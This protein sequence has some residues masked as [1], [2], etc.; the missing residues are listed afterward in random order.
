MCIECG[1]YKKNPMNR[2]YAALEKRLNNM[3]VN[4]R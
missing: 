3:I 4:Y 2:G 1:K